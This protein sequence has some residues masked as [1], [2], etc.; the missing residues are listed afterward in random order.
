MM[1]SFSST[2]GPSTE[3]QKGSKPEENEEPW[4]AQ[5][6]ATLGDQKTR[7]RIHRL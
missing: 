3:N 2:P 1:P 5:W 7:V 6:Q 4:T